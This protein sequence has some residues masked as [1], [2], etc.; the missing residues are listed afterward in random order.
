MGAGPVPG[1]L[2]SEMFPSRVRAKAM[3]ICMAVHWVTSFNFS[4]SLT[5]CGWT[6]FYNFYSLLLTLKCANN[7]RTISNVFL[8]KM[9]GE[10]PLDSLI[11]LSFVSLVFLP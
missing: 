9:N 8:T 11:S 7:R 6:G 3:S 4:P 2:L 5:S 10:Q 1:L